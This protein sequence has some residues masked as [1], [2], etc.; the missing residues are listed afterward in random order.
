MNSSDKNNSAVYEGTLA[1]ILNAEVSQFPFR[2]FVVSEL[3]PEEFYHDLLD[4]LPRT[5]QF[6][7][8]GDEAR[9]AFP[10]EPNAIQALDPAKREFWTSLSDFLL[11]SRL[12]EALKQKF[13]FQDETEEGCYS[14]VPKAAITRSWSGYQL[15]PHTDVGAKVA[16]FIIYLPGNNNFAEFGTE[17]YLPIDRDFECDGTSTRHNWEHFERVGI[18]KFRM[19]TLT[20]ICRSN[21]SFH[22]VPLNDDPS[23]I[24]DT[25]GYTLYRKSFEGT[26][27]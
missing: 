24:R 8:T 27:L 22:G 11:G 9:V 18:S 5:D 12:T 10:L 17:F 2:H 20:A 26:Q 23:F 19:N 16:S 3:F 25:I 13:G 15:Q 6:N 1:R 4:S 21:S 14:Y 7:A